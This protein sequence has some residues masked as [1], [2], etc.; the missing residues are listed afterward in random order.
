MGKDGKRTRKKTRSSKRG[1]ARVWRQTW[2]CVCASFDKRCRA[3]YRA[4]NHTKYVLRF[5][6]LASF[7]FRRIISVGPPQV[8]NGAYICNIA[9]DTLLAVLADGADLPSQ[10]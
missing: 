3:V 1:R 6:C 9:F 8:D 5:A 7:L 10:R 4:P 2:L